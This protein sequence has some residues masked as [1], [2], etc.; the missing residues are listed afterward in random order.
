VAELPTEVRERVERRYRG[1]TW[2]IYVCAEPDEEK[3][4]EGSFGV[5]RHACEASRR[6]K[7]EEG[8]PAPQVVW[9]VVGPVEYKKD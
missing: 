3:C 7:R 9:I 2:K 4:G 1:R 6:A 8:A 5:S